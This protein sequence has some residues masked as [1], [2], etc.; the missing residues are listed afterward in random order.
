MGEAIRKNDMT[1]SRN[2][3]GKVQAENQDN[4]IVVLT[5]ELP[6]GWREVYPQTDKTT[7][8]VPKPADWK[9]PPRDC[10]LFYYNRETRESTFDRPRG[11]TVA[12]GLCNG[13]GGIH[14]ALW[15]HNVRG[16]SLDSKPDGP[17][18]TL[19]RFRV[20][21]GVG[22]PNE[23]QF[24]DRTISSVLKEYLAWTA[25]GE[26]IL[27]AISGGMHNRFFN[28]ILT[29]LNRPAIE[30]T[31]KDDVRKAIMQ[32]RKLLIETKYSGKSVPM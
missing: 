25:G 17:W 12:G 5:D 32:I 14:R 19:E 4:W 23:P 26:H 29:A 16:A 6:L 30:R 9:G 1:R 8:K 11:I 24:R 15:S 22:T 13:C 27:N 20:L 2:G 10:P 18:L 21:I 31:K 7:P 3:R 28:N